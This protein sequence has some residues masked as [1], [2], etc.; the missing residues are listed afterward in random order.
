MSLASEITSAAAEAQGILAEIGGMASGAAGNFTGPDGKPYTMVFRAADAFETEAAG[1]Q[2]ASHGYNDQTVVVATA[3]RDQFAAVPIDWRA[4]HGTRLVPS[5][6]QD[7]TISTVATD[8]PYL[9]VF[10]MIL[11]QS[12]LPNG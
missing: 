1:L 10:T 11:K 5:P 2:M 12:T 4:R 3:T 7:V 6:A 8:D 9:F